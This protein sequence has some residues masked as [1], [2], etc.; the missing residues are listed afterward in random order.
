MR[1]LLLL[2]LSFAAA[3]AI[4]APPVATV[5]RLPAEAKS[6]LRP[7]ERLLDI[8]AADLDGDGLPDYVL[9]VTDR[10][11]P[12]ARE[13]EVRTLKIAVRRADGSFAI[14]AANPNILMCAECGGRWPDPLAGVTAGSKTFSIHHHWGGPGEDTLVYR[15]RYSRIDR[16]WQLVLWEM[17]EDDGK[18]V[19]RRTPAQFGKIGIADFV[20]GMDLDHPFVPPAP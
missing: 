10:L 7:G 4:A 3:A 20:E 1:A 14:V 18:T 8:K 15:F 11:D 12:D 6:L 9:A 2:M 17:R 5:I 19:T 16:T 13:D